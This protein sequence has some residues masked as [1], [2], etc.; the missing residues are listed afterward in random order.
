MVRPNHQIRM[1]KAAPSRDSRPVLSL[2]GALL[3]ICLIA[4]SAGRAEADPLP[5]LEL[6][7]TFHAMGV[8]VSIDP[9]DDVDGDASVAV[10]Y[11]SVSQTFRPAFPPSRVAPDRF[12]GSLF[13]LTPGTEYDVKATLSDPDGGPLDGVQLSASGE[14]RLEVVVPLPVRSH[15][16]SPDGAGVEC[17]LVQPCSLQ[18]GINLAEAGHEVVLRGG[19]YYEGELGFSRSGGPGTPIALRGHEGE[20]AILDGADP[21]TFQWTPQGGGVYKTTINVADTT[22]VAAEG[23]RLFPYSSFADLQGLVWDEPGF[24]VDGTD[25]YVRLDGDA[26]PGTKGMAVSRF[27][28]AFYVN[29]DFIGFIDLTFRHYGLVTH[30]KALF[31]DD[32]SDILVQGSTF[33]LN[34]QGIK[35]KN[36]SHR[37]VIEDNEFID[38]ISGWSWDAIKLGAPFLEPGG[39]NVGEPMIGRGNVIRRNVFHGFFDGLS[40]C[41]SGTSAVTSETDV[42]ENHAYRMEDDG[43]QADGRCTNVRIWSNKVDD[44]LNGISLSPVFGGP[45]Y[46]LRNVIHDAG[47]GNNDHLGS[48]FKFIYGVSSDGPVYLFHNTFHGGVSGDDGLMVGG[49]DGTWDS[50]VSR[51]NIWAGNKYGLRWT[52]PDQVLDF[53]YD[54]IH[55]TSPTRA[56]AWRG[57]FADPFL[58]TLAD[59]QLQ[60]GQELNGLSVAPAF[61]DA[62]N[63]DFRLVAD[64]ELVD[65]GLPIPGINDRGP[66]AAYGAAPDLGAFES[67]PDQ[68]VPPVPLLSWG[69][70]VVLAATLAVLRWWR[71]TTTSE[72]E[73]T[74][75]GTRF[76]IDRIMQRHP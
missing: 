59:L 56:V 53:D 3:A 20:I 13:W 75:R 58:D 46:A 49:E 54:V 33:V 21:E 55:T 61:I 44:I 39:V 17:S 31:I 5:S 14:T 50:I 45:V 16:V 74:R 18:Q 25:L 10:E 65:V 8:L 36:G 35:V 63:G 71:P 67:V 51:N 9:S 57:G 60:T 38:S 26:D 47:G 1:R 73:R 2:A 30:S 15:F 52:H 4:L 69:W 27:Q 32:G 48:P 72:G 7:G 22:L 43:M 23:E 34:N 19:V 66:H 24:Y 40:V 41:P 68:A 28:Q 70:L 64:S 11:R 6:Y 29:D 37:N 42:Y 76:Q 62:A 12:V